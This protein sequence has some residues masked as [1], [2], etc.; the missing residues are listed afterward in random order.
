MK[1]NLDALFKAEAVA[2]IGASPKVEAPG[3]MTVKLLLEK[4]YSGDIFFVNPKYE[5]IKGKKCYASIAD[6]PEE[7]DLVV[8][9]VAAKIV[10]PI[11][12]QCGIKGVKGVIIYTAG[13]SETRDKGLS[14][15]QQE[16]QEIARRYDMKIMGPNCVGLVNNANHLWATF[17]TPPLF[18]AGYQPNSLGIISQSGFF[19]IAIYQLAAYN[20]VGF[21]YFASVG[22]QADLSF[23]DFFK[24]MAQ[25]PDINVICGYLEGLKSEEDILPVARLAL[26]KQKPVVLIKVGSTE[27]GSQ[28]A[29][30]HTGA[31]A[32]K[33][34]NYAALF[35]QTGIARADDF[36]QLMA[37]L[38][39][40]LMPRKPKGKNTGIISCSGGATVM[41]ADK[42]GKAGLK[43]TQLHH[44]TIKSLD[45]MLPNYATSG[46]PLD[47][48]GRVLE[49]PELFGKALEALLDDPGLDT[50][51]I[52]FH[53]SIF[54]CW[55]ALSKLRECL[56]GKG[57]SVIIVGQ[58]L[59]PEEDV[60]DVIKETRRLGIPMI[61]DMN[62]A[63]WALSSYVNWWEKSL[64]YKYKEIDFHGKGSSPAVGELQSLPE[65]LGGEI[66]KKCGIDIPTGY[67]VK[68][69]QEAAEAVSR[70]GST[71]VLKIQSRDILHKTE[72]GGVRLNIT[73]SEE[74]EKVYTEIMALARQYNKDAN[75]DGVLVQE[76]LPP[77]HEIII[78][79]TRDEA[80]GPVIM[81]GL[82]GV[83]AEVLEDVSLRVAPLTEE[84]A[85]EMVEEIKGFKILQG[86][87]GAPPKD[88]E[89]IV[90]TLM[91]VSELAV[92]NPDIKELDLNPVIVYSS[93]EGLKVAD[94]LIVKQNIN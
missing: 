27:A 90:S 23:T 73:S 38:H 70:L 21:R 71:A 61:K 22:N 45:E 80:L 56:E 12:E 7:V 87:R 8:L 26:A 16:M 31:L 57:K 79:M 89:A 5:E 3:G 60:D 93:G 78:G 91:K 81:F 53:I 77:G 1:N 68:S 49:E 13:F 55:M 15:A 76:M 46:N 9:A 62:Y 65:Y 6:V 25:D 58:P 44:K 43:V 33:E 41:L 64:A 19:G 40:A 14:N 94:V 32:G 4:G 24:Y 69:P 37:F 36:E 30:S 92:K 86:Y 20:G 28:A 42:C 51:L 88:I 67:L 18:E 82:G 39:I 11:L 47:L 35:K 83:F 75:I 17:A 84:D 85:R 66:L 59:G 48:T 72:A 74:G 10:L 50:I 52:S 29:R 63:V 2:I 34:E 54:Y